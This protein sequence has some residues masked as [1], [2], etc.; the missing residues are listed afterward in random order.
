MYF[1]NRTPAH[2]LKKDM[3]SGIDQGVSRIDST[4][5]GSFAFS[6]IRHLKHPKAQQGHFNTAVQFYYLHEA[7]LQLFYW[8]RVTQ[9]D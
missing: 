2:L 5:N 7:I 9:S 4:N 8:K 1:G 6:V 3:R